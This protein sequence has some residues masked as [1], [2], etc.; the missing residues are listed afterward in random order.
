[1]SSNNI[2][3]IEENSINTIKFEP[4]F[5]FSNEKE[6][7]LWNNK[8]WHIISEANV[9]FN[10]DIF[11][12]VVERW[13][14]E[15]HLVIPPIERVE[16]I[17]DIE[18]ETYQGL[19]HNELSAN[20]N[21]VRSIKRKLIPKRKN[22]D[23]ELEELVEYYMDE[24]LNESRVIYTPIISNFKEPLQENIPFYYPKVFNFSYVYREYNS[25]S[26]IDCQSQI[27]IEII[28]LPQSVQFTD[29]MKYVY[30]QLFKKLYKWCQNTSMGY[31][32]R[33]HHDL[34][35][36]K[37]LYKET[38]QRLKSKYATD[39][40]RNWT[41]KTDPIK[42]VFEDIAIASWL[43]AL[44][45][46]ERIEQKSSKLQTFIDLGCGNGLLTFILS[47]EGYV[48]FGIDL[49]KRKIWDKFIEKGANLIEEA[50][51]P[52]LITYPNTDWIIGNHA[53]ELVPW[54]PIIASKSSPFTKLMVI[55][56]CFYSL[57]GLKYTFP[58]QIITS[59]KYKAYQE[60]IQDIISKCGFITEIDW[61]RIPSTK[62]V[63]LVGRKRVDIDNKVKDQ[64]N[65]LILDAG[66]VIIRK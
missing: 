28:P 15:V 7:R 13:T 51:Q 30:K 54:I 2:T 38:Y 50:I 8:L 56:C 9:S 62:N 44:W 39:L 26:D 45:E 53:D 47:S 57:T 27:S 49:K 32:K 66:S 43:I 18:N 52:N 17:S 10:K 23:E 58:N 46:L 34:L 24:N 12:K 20:I 35:V 11:W 6:S 31:E 59:G 42:F 55:P 14:N 33:F 40:V 63:V 3:L 29:K 41:E 61:L 19:I 5:Y 21:P 22:K 16:I 4:N 48:G 64:I 60:Y 36:P 1:M 65:Q 37:E 25:D